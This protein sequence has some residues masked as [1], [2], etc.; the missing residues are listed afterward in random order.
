MG[1]F[2][3]YKE[4]RLAE[5]LLKEAVDKLYEET[6]LE[7]KYLSFRIKLVERAEPAGIIPE[8][9][10]IYISKYLI[11]ELISREERIEE[12][13]KALDRERKR[14]EELYKPPISQGMEILKRKRI[15]MLENT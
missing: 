15:E 6:G 10:T 14:I 4:K 9:R 5:R 2:Q 13:Y 7:P 8:K 1:L 3:A 12:L 11:R